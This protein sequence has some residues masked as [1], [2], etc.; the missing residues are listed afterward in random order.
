MSIRVNQ[1]TLAGA[2]G[3]TVL[4]DF[5]RYYSEESISNIVPEAGIG[6]VCAGF[7]H[8]DPVCDAAFKEMSARGKL[9]LKTRVR[10]NRNSGNKFYFAVFDFAKNGKA[11][12]GF[13]DCDR[14][15]Y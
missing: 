6:I 3:V 10:K 4:S 7:I 8:K 9:L 14:N 12:Y 5:D 13:D 2:C 1:A 11:K 15:L